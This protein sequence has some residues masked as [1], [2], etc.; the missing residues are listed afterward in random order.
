MKN[1]KVF[2][3]V[4]LIFAL[5]VS[6]CS[7]ETESDSA[8]VQTESEESV[9]EVSKGFSTVYKIEDA[10]DGYF[11]VS[12][13]DGSLY[14][15]LDSSGNE[16]I[17]LEYDDITFP[18]SREAH[19]VVVK[20]EG[21]MGLYDYEGN[22]I[23]PLEYEDISDSGLESQYYLVEQGGVQSIIHLDGRE[24]KKLTGKYSSLVGD[25]FLVDGIDPAYTEVYNFNEEIL[26]SGEIE[27]ANASYAYELESVPDYIGICRFNSS[28]DLMDSNGNIV[29]S[30]P[31]ANSDNG[32]GM[33]GDINSN[34]LVTI[35]YYPN[36][37]KNMYHPKLLNISQNIV[38]EKYYNEITNSGD[39]IFAVSVSDGVNGYNV[40]VYNLNGTLEKTLAFDGET[41]STETSNSLISVKNGE[42]YRLYDKE[43]NDL[44]NERYLD[45]SPI[46]SFWVL[47]NLDGEYGL[48]DDNGDMR[49]PFGEM[50]NE[51]Y[52][53]KEWD[54]TYEFDDT[55][56]IVTEDS[57]GC[58]VWMF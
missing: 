36:G 53:G 9:N 56:C 54:E 24:Y 17:P 5:V 18:E 44:T 13:L 26:F 50:G 2:F 46:N 20:A 52:G 14:G 16:V 48:M 38:S 27:S 33:M 45:A 34:Q 30:Y 39:V 25:A 49:I 23:L 3:F 47:Q 6:G 35:D 40:D 32:Y 7:G 43:G 8:P 1:K 28:M 51:S 19:A 29:L 31:Y 37:I 21:K 10:K 55:F 57:N 42:T 15:L 22:E 41:V 11:I 12:K 58:N 4:C